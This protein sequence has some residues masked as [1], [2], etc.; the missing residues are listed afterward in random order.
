MSPLAEMLDVSVSNATGLIDRIE[1]RG[2]IER[3]RVPSDRR[4]VLVRI[5]AAGRA[6]LGEVEAG[7]DEIL[8]R[9][10]DEL[11]PAQLS[12]LAAAMGDL[13]AALTST[14]ASHAGAHHSHESQGRI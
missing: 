3:I 13:R 6:V 7:R 4:I 10:L 14:F 1:E 12:R 5:T 11:D 9:M 2:Y 8:E